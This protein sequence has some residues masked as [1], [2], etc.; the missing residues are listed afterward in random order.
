[1]FLSNKTCTKNIQGLEIFIPIIFFEV[2]G[3]IINIMNGNQ[4]RIHDFDNEL[5]KKLPQRQTIDYFT[6]VGKYMITKNVLNRRRRRIFPIGS[7]RPNATYL[8]DLPPAL[9]SSPSVVDMTTTFAHIST[10]KSKHVIHAVKWTPD[11]RR[12]LVSSYSGEFTLWNGL[13]F[14]FESIMQAHDVPIFSLEYSKSGKWLLSGDQAGC[15]KFWQPNFNNVNI[16]P[17]A[18]ENCIGNIKF[19]PNDSKFVSCSDDQTLKIWDFTTASEECTLKGHHWDVKDCDWHSSL[20]LIVSGSKDNIVKLWDPRDGSC[21]TTLHDFKHTVSKTIFQKGGNERLLAA[22]SRDHSTRIFDLR[23]LR[24]ISIIKSENETDLTSLTWH[25]IH[26]T[27]LT[28]GGYDGSLSHYDLTKTADIETFNKESLKSE[29]E[30]NIIDQQKA[31]NDPEYLYNALVSRGAPIISKPSH[32]IPFAHDKAVYTMEYHPLGHMLCT[33]GADKSMRFWSR[34][35]PDD[36]NGFNDV[37]HLGI[38]AIN[39]NH[40]KAESKEENNE[41][42]DGFSLPG[43]ST[44]PGFS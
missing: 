2:I 24:A 30:I 19:S 10:N 31:E 43:F 42:Q 39:Q 32:S 11:A 20:G 28:I 44:I 9:I 22:C 15:I 14:G 29:S 37:S 34:A 33:A 3:L 21:V 25:P 17:K 26:S 23:M 35:R 36:E 18:H 27:L 1:M 5:D 12:V 16:I 7:I 41:M 4:R 38:D 8:T 13:T 6:P 40:E